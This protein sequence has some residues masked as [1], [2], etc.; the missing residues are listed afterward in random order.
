[1]AEWSCKRQ[2]IYYPAF[3]RKKN[4]VKTCEHCKAGF[5]T[6]RIKSRFCS[7]S[8]VSKHKH[9]LIDQTGSKNPN[10]KGP[11]A[12][13]NYQHKKRWRL[14]NPEKAF[15]HDV[16]SAAIRAGKVTRMP[17]AVCGNPKT[18]G[19]HEDYSKPLDVVWLCRKHHAQK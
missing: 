6:Y 13:S 2:D 1:M 12:L 8:C 11:L 15:A 18:D 7:H 4:H 10:Y 16:F 19:H 5:E 14:R 9:S 17:C 3:M